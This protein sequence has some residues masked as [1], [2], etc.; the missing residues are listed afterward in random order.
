[1]S[2]AD[3]PVDGEADDGRA[4]HA[5]ERAD[6]HQDNGDDQARLVG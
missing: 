5:E 3:A 2:G 1:M 4:G 6:R